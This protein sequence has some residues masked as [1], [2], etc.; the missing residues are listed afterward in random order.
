MITGYILGSDGV[1]RSVLASFGRDMIEL[2]P[3]REKSA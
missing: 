1:N 2:S 3:H